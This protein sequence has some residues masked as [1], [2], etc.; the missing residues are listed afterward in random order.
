MR[1]PSGENDAPMYCTGGPVLASRTRPVSSGFTRTSEP[2]WSLKTIRPFLPGN[3]E[4][5]APASTASTAVAARTRASIAAEPIGRR[6]ELL[7][8]ITGFMSVTPL[9]C[10]EVEP[11]PHQVPP[12]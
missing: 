10:D 1:V 4:R 6:R 12:G 11:S 7:H 9:R 5:E 3:A 2:D 8:L